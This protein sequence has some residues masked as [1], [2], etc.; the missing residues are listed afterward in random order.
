LFESLLPN[1]NTIT[2]KL[3]TTKYIDIDS[4]RKSLLMF[5]IKNEKHG[6]KIIQYIQSIMPTAKYDQ[7]LCTG[8]HDGCTALAQCCG[9]SH[10]FSYLFVF[11]VGVLWRLQ[12][13]KCTF[14]VEVCGWKHNVSVF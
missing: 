1:D 5:A 13:T 9:S 3:L 10:P 14:P 2:Q 6:F 11:R 4:K 8:D 7:W 12:P